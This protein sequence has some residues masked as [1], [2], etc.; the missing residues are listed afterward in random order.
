MKDNLSRQAIPWNVNKFNASEVSSPCC[1]PKCN[2]GWRF[3]NVLWFQHKN[4]WNMQC[5]HT[6]TGHQLLLCSSLVLLHW[7]T[8]HSQAKHQQVCLFLLTTEV[9]TLAQ[10]QVSEWC[11][12]LPASAPQARSGSSRGWAAVSSWHSPWGQSRT[13]QPRL[14]ATGMLQ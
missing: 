8:D 6:N 13:V 12:P 5:R 14:C 2:G 9:P 10:A 1:I 11:S 3:E 4:A 7:N